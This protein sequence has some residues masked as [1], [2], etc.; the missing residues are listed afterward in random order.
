AE[1]GLLTAEVRHF[2]ALEGGIDKGEGWQLLFNPPVASTFSG[3]ATFH[4]PIQIPAGR[5]GLQPQVGLSYNSRQADGLRA[6]NHDIDQWPI[7]LGWSLDSTVDIVRERT[8]VSG[9]GTLNLFGAF[10]LALNGAT[11]ELETEAGQTY[12]RY[13]ARNM[14]GLYIERFNALCENDSP[15]LEEGEEKT[16]DYWIVRQPDG[17]E[18]Q[19]GCT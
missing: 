12:G 15:P 6:K 11:H 7:G 10:S 9:N 14:P 18:F 19:L 13:R 16:S 5:N 3:A 1:T 8:K 4:Y 17:T 2:S